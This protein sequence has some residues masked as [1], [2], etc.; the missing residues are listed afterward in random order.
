MFF[1]PKN[2]KSESNNPWFNVLLHTQSIV[3]AKVDSHCLEY[4][5][6]ITL[7]LSCKFAE[8]HP[9]SCLLWKRAIFLQ[10]ETNYD[11]VQGSYVVTVH[12]G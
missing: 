2:L 10:K 8:K 4:L 3:C 5:R 7:S 11:D 1:H 12:S 6:C 9:H